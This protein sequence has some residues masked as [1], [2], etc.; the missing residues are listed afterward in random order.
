MF[1]V[2][3]LFLVQ[4]F[5]FVLKEIRIEGLKTV[6][7]SE[8]EEIYKGYINKDVNEQAVS[9]IVIGIDDTGYFE[10]VSYELIGDDKAKVLKIKVKENPPV[11]KLEIVLNGPGLVDKETLKN[12]ISLAEKKAFSFTKFWDSINNLAKLYSDKGYLVATPRSQDRSLAFVYVSGT[13]TGD[14]VKFTITEYV[15]YKLEFELISK[16]EELKKEFERIKKE[17]SL[18]QYADYERKNWLERIFDSEK[19]YVPTLKDLQNA[20]Q[21]LSRYVYFTLANI[22][23]EETNAKYPAKIL[24]L[25]LVENTVVSEPVKLKGVRT[26]GNTVFPERELVGEVREGTYSN[27][28]I[29]K[30]IQTVREKYDKAGY[31]IDLSLEPD[32]EGYLYI[33]VTEY[34][35]RDVKFE[36]NSV[37]KSHVFDDMVYVKPGMLLNRNDLQ[38]TYVELMKANFFKSIDFDFRPVQNE[39]SLVDVVVKLGEKDKKFDFQGGITYGPPKDGPWWNGFAAFVTLS[40][41]N[42]TGHGENLSINVQKWIPTTNINLST[43]I[44]RPFGWPIILG[45]GIK[46]DSNTTESGTSTTNVV[47]SANLGTIKTPLGQLSTEVRFEDSTESSSTT[48]NYKTLVTSASYIYE[49]LDNLY[50]PMS[51]YSVTLTANKYFPFSETGSDAFS[52]LGELTLHLPLFQNLSLASRVLVGQSFQTSGKPVTFSLTGLNQV[53]GVNTSDSG[54]VIG[55]FNSEIRYKEK[56]QMFY[57][58]LFYDAGFV[59]NAFDFANIKQSV[60]VEFGLTVPLFGLIRLGWGIPIQAEIKPNFFILFGKTF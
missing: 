19:N 40:T 23:G 30:K 45:A 54:S 6:K 17:V 14:V 59:S 15:L 46:F 60:G 18:R 39:K 52:Y 57:G 43:G 28:A 38:L 22:S 51:G 58:S 24:N 8:L 36:G 55:L 1:C 56:D 2:A 9:D 44:R 10:D 13:I 33:V 21:S 41:T 20:V 4:A 3:S 34:K 48:L 29:L 16:D 50:I 47:Y 7:V 25:T 35:V 49:T 12:S 27:F 53:R 31:F 42:P 5:G 37:T 32:P 11:Q 26:K